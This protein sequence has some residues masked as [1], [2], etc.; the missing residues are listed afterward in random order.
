VFPPP[1]FLLFAS[2]SERLLLEG[3][4]I[5]DDGFELGYLLLWTFF[6]RKSGF[7]PHY[8]YLSLFFLFSRFSRSI[9]DI[10]YLDIGSSVEI[11]MKI[12]CISVFV[13]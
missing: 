3:L 11:S 9:W 8:P 1:S 4:I 6:S 13:G 10:G 7:P 12:S 2:F 5:A